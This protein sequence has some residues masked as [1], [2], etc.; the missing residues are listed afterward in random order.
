[1]EV[2]IVYKDVLLVIVG[3]HYEAEE[4]ELYDGNLSG[5]PGNKE[6]FEIRSVYVYDSNADIIEFFSEDDLD[7]IR[8]LIL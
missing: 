6:S 1:M 8:E 4:R 3:E 5:H 7:D 2:S